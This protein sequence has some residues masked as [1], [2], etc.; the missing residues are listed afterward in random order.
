MPGKGKYTAY[1]GKKTARSAFLEKLYKDSPFN[2]VDE[3]QAPALVSQMG[4]QY[5]VPSVQEGNPAL[6]PQGVSLDYE[7]ENA[8]D[9]DDVKWSKKGDAATAFF[10]NLESPGAGPDGQV[11][12]APP[13]SNP[14]ITVED[15]KPTY[16]PGVPGTSADGGTGTVNPK[17]TTEKIAQNV[18]LGKDLVMGSSQKTGQ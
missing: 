7:H 12:T 5:L 2:G 3:E 9:F 11:N 13:E 18:T 1:V 16:V 8:P 15:V 10:P 6:F 17:A 4:N 14:E